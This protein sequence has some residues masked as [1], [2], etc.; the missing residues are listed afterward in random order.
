MRDPTPDDPRANAAPAV[1]PTGLAP[2][3]R[4]GVQQRQQLGDVV[5]VAAGDGDRERDPVGIGQQVV[6]GAWPAPVDRTWADRL[7]RVPPSCPHVGAI[8][9]RPRPVDPVGGV[10]LG[11]QELVEPSQTPACCQSRSRRR[12]VIPEP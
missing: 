8:G 3:R 5:A 4:D 12:Q 7:A 1:R 10:Q 11:Q 6:L 2:H 9:H